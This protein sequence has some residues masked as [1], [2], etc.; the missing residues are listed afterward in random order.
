MVNKEIERKFLVL[1]DDFKKESFK[2]ERIVQGF[3]SS[4][5]ERTVRVRISGEKG[6]ITV[7]G[8]GN[9]SGT[10]RFE[11]EKEID[12]SEAE[13]LLLICEPGT[14]EKIRYFVK[15]GAHIFEIDEFGLENQG[16]TVAEIELN[17]EEESY[18][19]PLWLGAEV[20]GQ[21]KY[22]NSSLARKPFNQW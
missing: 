15:S 13:N 2:N 14:I 1:N 10:T 4:V 21:A 22:Y 12:V 5:P 9:R 3:L 16:L 17:D 20:T 19:K 18:I 8:I 11:W 7:K 6:F